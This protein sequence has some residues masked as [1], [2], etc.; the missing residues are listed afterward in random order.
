[1]HLAWIFFLPLQPQLK[2]DGVW[3]N[4]N[5]TDSGPV[6]PGSSPGTP[7]ESQPRQRLFFMLHPYSR[8]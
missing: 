8:V 4:G 2:N 3:C 5:T 6:I 1:M 7:T